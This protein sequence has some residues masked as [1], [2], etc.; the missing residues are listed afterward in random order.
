LFD[1][2][3]GKC[4]VFSKKQILNTHILRKHKQAWNLLL[5][6]KKNYKLKIKNKK[7]RE[8]GHAATLRRGKGWQC[9]PFDKGGQTATP[10]PLRVAVHGGGHEATSLFY[11]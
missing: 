5:T 9:W 2:L 7:N 11:Y 1:E 3:F 8:R 6:Y 10:L 4:S